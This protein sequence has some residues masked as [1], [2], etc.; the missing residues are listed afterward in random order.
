MGKLHVFL[1]RHILGPFQ[2]NTLRM[3]RRRGFIL[4]AELVFVL[5]LVILVVSGLVELGALLHG[6]HRLSVACWEGARVASISNDPALV[7]RMVMDVLGIHSTE[8]VSV[9]L[10]TAHGLQ[11]TLPGERIQIVVGVKLGCFSLM[12]TNLFGLSNTRV[13]CETVTV[14]E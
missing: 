12:T 11:Q 5:P 14:R 13:F 3:E 2:V 4:T 10:I 6:Q 8:D 7:N 1:K 9:D